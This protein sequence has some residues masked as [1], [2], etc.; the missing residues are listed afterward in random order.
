MVDP[1]IVGG[2]QEFNL[3]SSTENVFGA[4]ALVNSAKIVTSDIDLKNAKIS[5]IRQNIIT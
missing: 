4:L 2:G 3:R 5:Q 1:L